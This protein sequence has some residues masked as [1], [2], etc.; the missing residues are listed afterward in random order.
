MATD[1]KLDP[2]TKKLSLIG[3][4]GDSNLFAAVKATHIIAI[5]P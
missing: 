4:G 5:K 2:N 1:I 3:F